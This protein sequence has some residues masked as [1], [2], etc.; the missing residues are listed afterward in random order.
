MCSARHATH[1]YT[2]IAFVAEGNMSAEI[3]WKYTV[4]YQTFLKQQEE[5]LTTRA[6]IVWDIIFNLFHTQKAN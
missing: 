5:K 3:G 2:D 1:V 6:S 4:I